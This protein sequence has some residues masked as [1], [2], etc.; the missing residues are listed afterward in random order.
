MQNTTYNINLKCIGVM[1]WDNLWGGMVMDHM[2]KCNMLG[3][4]IPKIVHYVVPNAFHVIYSLTH[5]MLRNCNNASQC[6][7]EDTTTFAT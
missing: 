2:H 7:E 5:L 4:H 1:C 3:Q 6:R